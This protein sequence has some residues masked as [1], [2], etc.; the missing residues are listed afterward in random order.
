MRFRRLC[1]LPN[2]PDTRRKAVR[3]LAG[4]AHD[5]ETLWVGADRPDGVRSVSPAQVGHWLGR[6]VEALVFVAT[7]PLAVD[8]L[9]I[10]SGLLRGGGVLLLL[11]D[12]PGPGTFQARWQTALA[13]P[14]A[15]PL[16]PAHPDQWPRPDRD[17]RGRRSW[18][19][20]QADALETLG[21]MPEHGCEVLIAPRGRG[22]S[23]V[24]GEWMGRT[25]QARAAPP[26]TLTAPSPD[27]VRALLDQAQRAAKGDHPSTTYRAPDTLITGTEPLHTLIVDEAAALPVDRLLRLAKR[28]HRLVLATTTGGFE[29]SGQGFRLRALP[30]LQRA[31]FA[32]RVTRLETPVRW[33]P[34]DPLEAWLNRLFLLNA[35]SRPPA[36]QALRWRSLRGR[37]LAYSPRRLEAI[38]GLLAD[39]HYRTR[40]S[41]LA[42]WLEDPGIQLELL[43]GAHDKALFGVALVQREPG[44]KPATAEDVWAGERRPQGHFLPCVLAGLGA[45]ELAGAPAWRVHRIAVHP[46]WQG[47]GLGQRLLRRVRD[48]ARAAGVPLLGASF[49]LQPGLLRFWRDAGFGLVRAGQR[50]DPASGRIGAVVLAATRPARQGAVDRLRAA[51]R[52]DW[53]TWSA[54]LLEDPSGEV[55]AAVAD[56]D[57]PRGRIPPAPVDPAE[58]WH[59]IRAFAMRARPLEWTLPALQRRLAARPPEDRE[60]RLLARACEPP[61]HW[62]RL[63]RELGVSGRRGATRRLRRATR[64]WLE[65][66]DA[67]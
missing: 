60:G 2:R 44:L 18:T 15:E 48:R 16:D 62:D 49:G 56:P 53:P 58:D 63:A 55:A 30:A 35:A 24:L 29:G 43:E 66:L 34:G 51:F 36:P 19:A 46:D 40:P 31:G 38:T 17:P 4:Q 8:A 3:W 59:S 67:E 1:T 13:E 27:S 47:H 45:L 10:A 65:R 21:Q 23:T 5:G 64:A 50:P 25:L 6:E 39:A 54:S 9:V 14:L 41:D 42:R 26:V 11:L 33:P 52:R 7:P 57:H 28:A 22:K 12:P 20:D 37:D 61:I 32:V